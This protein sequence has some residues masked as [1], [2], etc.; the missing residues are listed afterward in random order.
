M[1]A[2][3]DDTDEG[4][5]YGRPPKAYRFKPGVSGNPRGRPAKRDTR[6]SWGSLGA[7]ELLVANLGR[8]VRGTENGRST[9][10]TGLDVI[11]RRLIQKAA[12]GNVQAGRTLLTMAV[13]QERREAKERTELLFAALECQLL[14]ERR[15]NAAL[16]AGHSANDL[17]LHPRDI[18]INWSTGEVRYYL[19]FTQEQL[20]IRAKLIRALDEAICALLVMVA[21][22]A[23]DGESEFRQWMRDLAEAE[24]SF[25]NAHLPSR[26]RREPPA[27]AY[28]KAAEPASLPIRDEVLERAFDW[29]VRLL[30]N[31][32]Q[33]KAE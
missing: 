7:S 19:S 33:L 16:E 18:E 3:K 2:G 6:F 8:E 22:D 32:E 9:T 29:I 31:A 26:F 28:G 11:E 1:S 15:L 25:F 21:D 17:A 4:V 14:L 23:R 24:V 10:L 30:R 5:G 20:E 27:K 13:N 12:T